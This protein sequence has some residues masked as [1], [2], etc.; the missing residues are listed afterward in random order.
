LITYKEEKNLPADQLF[1]L[2]KSIK[3]TEGVKDE[4][5]HALLIQKVYENSDAVFS[6]WDNDKLV[7]VV[8]VITDQFAHGL[9]YGLAIK[10]DY[11]TDEIAKELISKSIS[12]YPEI[13]WSVETE[14]WEEKIFRDLGFENSKN[15]FL[16]KGDCPI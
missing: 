11:D 1:D 3:W 6:A 7:G 9:I 5:E 15:A 14:E 2:Y 16:N 10:P 8:R 4:E 13:R 12:L